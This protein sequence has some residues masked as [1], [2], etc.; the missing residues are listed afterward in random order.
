[1]A[2]AGNLI[3]GRYQLVD[4]RIVPAT[5]RIARLII[6][7]DLD[8][9]GSFA[10][11]ASGAVEAPDRLL[12]R[13]EEQILLFVQRAPADPAALDGAGAILTN[14]NA[15]YPGYHIVAVDPTVAPP[16]LSGHVVDNTTPVVFVPPTPGVGLGE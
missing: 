11:G 1:M 6:F 12:A 10:V 4:G 5:I 3:G 13:A 14:W 16:D 7:D 9:N 15:A 2:R 8:G